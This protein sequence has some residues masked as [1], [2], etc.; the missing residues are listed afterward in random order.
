MKLY[1]NPNSDAS[2]FV[3]NIISQVGLEYQFFI[4]DL[5]SME[6][7][8][9]DYLKMNPKGKVPVLQD[10]DYVLSESFAIARYAIDK[11]IQIQSLKLQGHF[12]YG[13]Q[14]WKHENIL[15]RC[16]QLYPTNP[17]E[18]AVIDMYA[19]IINELRINMI[20]L[21]YGRVVLP[22]RGITTPEVT[23]KQYEM[24]MHKLWQEF[25]GYFS[26]TERKYL[27]GGSNDTLVDWFLCQLIVD[28][29]ALQIDHITRYP[30]TFKFAV[31]MTQKYPSLA[32]GYDRYNRQVL[33]Y[34]QRQKL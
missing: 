6:Q 15:Q 26:D 31:N 24:N 28:H 32:D 8:S 33:E 1:V 27:C 29:D 21:F 14:R 3:Q 34:S 23:L 12:I 13:N 18:R 5:S 20:S 25:E 11:Q 30:N 7:R 2:R 16:Q 4:V 17:K 19:G 10:G 22:S 9:G